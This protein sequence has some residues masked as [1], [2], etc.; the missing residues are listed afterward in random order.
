MKPSLNRRELLQS[1][2]AAGAIAWGANLIGGSPG[3]SVLASAATS[4]PLIDATYHYELDMQAEGVVLLGPDDEVKKVAFTVNT[5]QSFDERAIIADGGRMAS[6]TYTKAELVKRFGALEP[7][8]VHLGPLP[9]DV[10][11]LPEQP[12]SGRMLFRSSQQA[13]TQQNVNLLQIPLSPMWLDELAVMIFQGKEKL[14]VGDRINLPHDLVA[15]LF[16]LEE[17][18][19]Q[20]LTCEVEKANDGQAVLRLVGDVTGR[21]LDVIAKIRLNASA[22]AVFATRTL[23]QV[24]ASFFEQREKGVVSPGYAV[25][26]KIKLDQ[27]PAD[28]EILPSVIREQLTLAAAA[29]V[30]VFSSKL[31]QVEFQHT[32]QW[33][34]V[35]EQK[36]AAI[37]RLIVDGEP[38]TQCNMLFPLTANRDTVTLKQFVEE[39]ES[40]L[41]GSVGR[42]ISQQAIKGANGLDL[43]R[44]Q[45]AGKDEDV[46]L[47]WA[48]YHLQDKNGRRAQLVFTTEAGLVDALG[49]SDLLIA[50]SLV[51]QASPVADNT[52]TTRR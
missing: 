32:P 31:N 52:E 42:I 44:V 10:I 39:V 9:L 22:R 35:L 29:P 1:V 11:A 7:E 43:L 19:E 38:M 14:A 46:E 45:V 20:S 16:C 49:Q 3:S 21:S 33:H 34:L 18:S 37:W 25:T 8:T 2:S 48:Y 51:L 24:R 17:V 41:Q 15:K 5:Q 47:V 13:L 36:G 30:F 28:R 6:R 26:T 23:T 27:S 4:A 50:Q 40:S 12:D